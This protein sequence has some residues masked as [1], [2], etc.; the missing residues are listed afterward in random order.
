MYL[1]RFQN[2]KV[3]MPLHRPQGLLVLLF[4]PSL[5]ERFCWFDWRRNTV[6]GWVAVSH[7]TAAESTI[8]I[9][10]YLCKIPHNLAHMFS[11]FNNAYICTLQIFLKCPTWSAF[12]KRARH[13]FVRV[14]NCFEGSACDKTGTVCWP[15]APPPYY[16][17]GSRG[18]GEAANR[19]R[20]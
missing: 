6:R 4:T 16:L 9:F 15:V 5:L 1:Y 13:I 11:W 14:L 12:A 19:C 17:P 7:H 2:F 3:Y 18:V 8:Y 20:H 10:A